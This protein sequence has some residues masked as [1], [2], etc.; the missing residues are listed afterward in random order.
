VYVSFRSR[1]SWGIMRRTEPSASV[2]EGLHTITSS[3]R[4]RCFSL[5][6]SLITSNSCFSKMICWTFFVK[7]SSNDSI[8]AWTS[9]CED[10]KDSKMS[11]MLSLVT[12]SFKRLLSLCVDSIVA[13]RRVV[14]TTFLT[15][16]LLFLFTFLTTLFCQIEKLNCVHCSIVVLAFFLN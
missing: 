4:R 2:I 7:K 1:A 11:R 5:R 15:P 9:P 8:C 14:I 10:I 3:M 12:I 6:R 13:K 16:N